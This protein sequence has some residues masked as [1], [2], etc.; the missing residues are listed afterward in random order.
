MFFISLVNFVSILFT[1]LHIFSK[2]SIHNFVLLLTSVFVYMIKIFIYQ[3]VIIYL[4]INIFIIVV[5]ITFCVILSFKDCHTD[6]KQCSHLR[7]VL[8]LAAYLNNKLCVSQ[9]SLIIIWNKSKFQFFN[10]SFAFASSI[11]FI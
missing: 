6:L 4:Y 9:L 8:I 3:C 11:N 5:Y 7:S 1:S 10:S 2:Y